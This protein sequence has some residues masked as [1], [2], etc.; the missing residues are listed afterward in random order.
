MEPKEIIAEH[1]RIGDL[2]VITVIYID[3]VAYRMGIIL[4]KE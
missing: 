1:K 4:F 3:D 2:S